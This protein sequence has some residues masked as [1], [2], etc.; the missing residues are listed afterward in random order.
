MANVEDSRGLFFS[1][2]SIGAIITK[3]KSTI[4]LHPKILKYRGR[5][6]GRLFV[7]S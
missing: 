2:V 3:A 1:I 4:C 5:E 6:G 7:L